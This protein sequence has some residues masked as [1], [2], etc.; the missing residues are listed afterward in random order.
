MNTTTRFGAIAAAA[1]LAWSLWCAGIAWFNGWDG[2]NWL[3]GFHWGAIPVCVVIAAASAVAVAQNCEPARVSLFVILASAMCFAAFAAGRAELYQMFGSVYFTTD[4]T[5]PVRLAL[6]AI[7]VS[8][9]LP[10][11]AGRLL[12]PLHRS[13]ALLAIGALTLAVLLAALT[14]AFFA[15]ERHADP[16]NAIRLGYPVFWTALLLPAALWIGAGLRK[17]HTGYIRKPR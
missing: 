5:P 16:Y 6:Y 12:A 8:V 14:V 9:S 17:L 1:V 15:G 4:A 11:L 3:R 13:A 7:A 2:L 10:W